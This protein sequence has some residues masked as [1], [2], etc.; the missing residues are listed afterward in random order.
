[1]GTADQGAEVRPRSWMSRGCI[2]VINEDARFDEQT[3]G[4]ISVLVIVIV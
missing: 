3:E 1:M 2:I 4:I